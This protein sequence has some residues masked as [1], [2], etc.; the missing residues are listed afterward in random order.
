MIRGRVLVPRSGQDTPPA[1]SESD[2]GEPLQSCQ[3]SHTRMLRTARARC[4][5][6]DVLIV[7]RPNGVTG[8]GVPDS[9]FSL[10]SSKA[11]WI[12]HVRIEVTHGGQV[13]FSTGVSAL[14]PFYVWRHGPDIGFSLGLS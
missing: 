3:L 9:L 8:Q 14:F 7:W 13:T 10:D 1:P 6:G 4:G 12:E 5:A 2:F 11:S